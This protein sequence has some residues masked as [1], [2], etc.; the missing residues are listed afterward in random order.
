MISLSVLVDDQVEMTKSTLFYVGLFAL[1]MQD[2]EFHV[3][4]SAILF[5]LGLDHHL[6]LVI[7]VV[8]SLLATFRT[9]FSLSQLFAIWW[10]VSGALF[11]RHRLLLQ[12]YLNVTYIVS[13]SKAQAFLLHQTLLNPW[14]ISLSPSFPAWT[15]SIESLVNQVWL[16]FPKHGFLS[17]TLSNLKGQ[18]KL[19]GLL[20]NL[21]WMLLWLSLSKSSSSTALSRSPRR[22][23][24]PMLPYLSV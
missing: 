10:W 22:L 6:W 9:L 16:F 24:A 3:L 23:L 8:L 4:G 5:E 18:C 11:G 13:P 7:A 17:R 14:N 12:L 2:W 19:C 20:T 15:W 1:M 21:I